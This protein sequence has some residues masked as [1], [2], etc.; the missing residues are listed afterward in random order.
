MN[1]AP[2]GFW[3]TSSGKVVRISEMSDSHLVSVLKIMMRLEASQLEDS[4][5]D[6]Y[7]SLWAEV[8]RRDLYD[9][10]VPL[11][12]TV[13]EILVRSKMRK[14]KEAKVAKDSQG[15]FR[16]LEFDEEED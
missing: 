9:A 13:P 2:K 10:V 3:R 12:G 5:S 7:E 15:R 4:S 16:N 11:R 6:T 1:R 8:G 14:A